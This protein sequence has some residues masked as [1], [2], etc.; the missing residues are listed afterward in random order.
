[1][2]CTHSRER[3]DEERHARR[4]EQRMQY[5]Q[6]TADNQHYLQQDYHRRLAI[7]HAIYND[8]V[9]RAYAE[10][11]ARQHE[12][13]SRHFSLTEGPSR[14]RRSHRHQHEGRR[15]TFP[16]DFNSHYLGHER[17]LRSHH[18]RRRSRV[19]DASRSRTRG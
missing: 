18:S 5:L 6:A 7:H 8:A 1:M 14:G 4:A 2:G 11:Y 17:I 3:R 9:S 16:R 12:R 19:H 10:E 13:P 15:E